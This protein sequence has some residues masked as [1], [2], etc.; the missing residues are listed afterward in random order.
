[1]SP[2]PAEDI[3]TTASLPDNKPIWPLP[4]L[5]V[6]DMVSVGAGFKEQKEICAYT[7]GNWK[8]LIMLMTYTVHEPN[9]KYP[10]HEITFIATDIWPADGSGI[11]V[12][13]LRWPFNKGSI[14]F[15][16]KK[17]PK[18]QHVEFFNIVSYFENG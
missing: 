11:K 13:K 14:T 2:F 6:P 10:Y 16:M 9:P 3:Q 17:D 8:T 7:Q 4:V 15:L 18:C 12:K 5:D 1:M